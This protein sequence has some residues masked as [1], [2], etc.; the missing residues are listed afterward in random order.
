[1]MRMYL[2][3]M[4]MTVFCAVINSCNDDVTMMMSQ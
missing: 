2:M 1:M 4:M 3:M